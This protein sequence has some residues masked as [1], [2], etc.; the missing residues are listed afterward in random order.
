[1]TTQDHLSIQDIKND[2]V[3]LKDGGAAMVL[4]TSAVNFGLL[5]EREQVA[6]ISAFAQ[7]LNSLSFMIQIVIISERLNIESYLKL[8]S[9]AEGRQSNPLLLKIM[10]DY[11]QFVQRTIKENDVLDKQ[12]YVVIPV[13]AIEMGIG[14]GKDVDVKK[15]SNLLTPKRDQLIRQFG[16]IGLKVTQLNNENLLRL[17]Y[18]LYNPQE[19]TPTIDIAPVNL[20]PVQQQPITPPPVVQSV[21]TPIL[22]TFP[23]T[24][25]PIVAQVTPQQP[26]LPQQPLMPQPPKVQSTPIS[27]PSKNHPFVVEE[28]QEEG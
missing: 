13:F 5:S 19:L 14:I 1:M 22:T 20:Q 8:L 6:I 25:K 21:T 4:Q 17:Y 23:T 28:L 26:Q 24:Q 7:L 3:L 27:Q 10:K 11:R 2:L 16:R 9:V 15:A 18:N 12:F